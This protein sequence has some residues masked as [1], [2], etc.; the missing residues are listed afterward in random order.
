MWMGGKVWG[1]QLWH[2]T[3]CISLREDTLVGWGVALG[4]DAQSQGTVPKVP[5]WLPRD[6]QQR[7]ASLPWDKWPGSKPEACS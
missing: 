3:S 5:V 4:L 7:A 6:R 2:P 1:P